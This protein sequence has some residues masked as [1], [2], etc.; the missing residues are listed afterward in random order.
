MVDNMTAEMAIFQAFVV[1]FLGFALL[2]IIA[3]E[4]SKRRK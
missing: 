4:I 1:C 2:A 3:D